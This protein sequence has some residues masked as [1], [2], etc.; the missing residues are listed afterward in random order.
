MIRDRKLSRT[1]ATS[2]A[3]CGTQAMRKIEFCSVFLVLVP[4][5]VEYASAQDGLEKVEGE[6]RSQMLQPFRLGM[7]CGGLDRRRIVWN[8]DSS[9]LGF[10]PLA[11]LKLRGSG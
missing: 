2:A 5:N 8:N 1:G 11:A 6:R 7:G 4:M 10:R 3:Q 9:V